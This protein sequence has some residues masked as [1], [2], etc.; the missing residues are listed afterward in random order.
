SRCGTLSMFSSTNWW[1]SIPA[2]R[3]GTHGLFLSEQ[4]QDPLLDVRME[5]HP[6][7]TFN[8]PRTCCGFRKTVYASQHW[9]PCDGM[10]LHGF[11]PIPYHRSVWSEISATPATQSGKPK[12][13]KGMLMSQSTIDSAEHHV[14]TLE[15]IASLARDAGRPADALMN[16]V[17][18]IAARFRTDVCSAYLLEPDR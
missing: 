10:T 11:R 17:A 18:L 8:P 16:V 5:E 14:L 15:Q 13:A 7:E 4:T 3:A 2:P 9:R 1:A 6:G 12:T